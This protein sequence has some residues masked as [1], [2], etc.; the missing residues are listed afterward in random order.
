MKS[1]R[2]PTT[3]RV[4]DVYDHSIFRERLS[5]SLQFSSRIKISTNEILPL[6]ISSPMN[7]PPWW[8]FSS[9]ID[10]FSI[11]FIGYYRSPNRPKPPFW[12]FSP[13]YRSIT[14]G[15]IKLSKKSSS[16]RLSISSFRILPGKICSG[17]SRRFVGEGETKDYSLD[18]FL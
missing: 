10:P 15:R 1:I 8:T 13:Q 3:N 6:K 18:F 11:S 7:S 17:M 16:H 12:K 14:N 5:I 2:S 4:F 9:K